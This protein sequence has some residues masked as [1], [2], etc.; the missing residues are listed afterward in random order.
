MGNFG[1]S[2]IIT[3]LGGKNA[4]CTER[5]NTVAQ[6]QLKVFKFFPNVILNLFLVQQ[7]SVFLDFCKKLENILFS[8]D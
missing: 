6:R 1:N 2:L 4:S 3:E 7:L 8:N 5:V